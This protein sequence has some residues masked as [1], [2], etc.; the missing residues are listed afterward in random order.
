MT[1]T[2]TSII[3]LFASSAVLACSSAGAP[4]A[5]ETSEE[6]LSTQEGGTISDGSVIDVWAV[7]QNRP[8]ISQDNLWTYERAKAGHAG[9]QVGSFRIYGRERSLSL[10][11]PGAFSTWSPITLLRNN[12]I[13]LPYSYDSFEVTLDPSGDIY[14]LP[15]PGAPGL[16][17]LVFLAKIDGW[18]GLYLGLDDARNSDDYD[19]GTLTYEVPALFSADPNMRSLANIGEADP[20]ILVWLPPRTAI[21]FHGRIY[22]DGTI[23]LVT[24][25]GQHELAIVGKLEGL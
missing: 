14:A 11:N 6:R 15:V 1:M 9:T 18:P 24:H 19:P 13:S 2:R 10:T 21:E 25:G 7:D 20:I 5:S 4:G 17:E 23:H 8:A 12:N 16:T 3:A 22:Q